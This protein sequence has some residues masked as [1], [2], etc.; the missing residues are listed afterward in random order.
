MLFLLPMKYHY[1]KPEVC[2]N[3]GEIYI[4]DH[5]LYNRCTLFKNEEKGLAIVQ[6]RFNRRTKTHWWSS[7]DPWLAGEL[8]F[9]PDFQNYFDSHAKAPDEYGLYPTVTIRKIMWAL[10]IKP[11]QKQYWEDKENFNYG[12]KT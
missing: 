12:Q 1:E 9:H 2:I 5:P 10:R 11:L 7:V 4:C 8:Y 6:E 3:A